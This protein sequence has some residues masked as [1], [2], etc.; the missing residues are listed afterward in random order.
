MDDAAA[1]PLAMA[2]VLYPPLHLFARHN[3][4]GGGNS[5]PKCKQ[6]P[7]NLMLDNN[8]RRC[9]TFCNTPTTSIPALLQP[10]VVNPN[11]PIFD[12]VAR[13]VCSPHLLSPSQSPCFKRSALNPKPL[14]PRLLQWFFFFFFWRDFARFRQRNWEYIGKC[15]LFSVNSTK[16]SKFLGLNFAKFSTFK[17]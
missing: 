1:E 8:F 2:L 5:E 9:C 16:I 15:C 3:S 7:P 17:I 10:G 13:C 12:F 14:V 11:I 6:T 4:G